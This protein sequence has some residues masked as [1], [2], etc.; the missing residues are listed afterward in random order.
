MQLGGEDVPVI[1]EKEFDNLFIVT[2]FGSE[3]VSV[4]KLKYGDQSSS[5]ATE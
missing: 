3:K 4:T 1:G 2:V 5:V